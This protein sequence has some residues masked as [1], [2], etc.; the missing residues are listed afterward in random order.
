MSSPAVTS[1]ACTGPGAGLLRIS[2]CYGVLGLV[3]L[4][5]AALARFGTS[6]SRVLAHAPTGA[7]APAVDRT[8]DPHA[9][10]EG[11]AMHT[12]RSSPGRFR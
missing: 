11:E 4:V 7:A 12:A 2:R 10:H 1:P 8:A 5:A 9:A 3:A 6:V